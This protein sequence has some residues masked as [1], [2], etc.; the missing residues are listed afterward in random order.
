MGDDDYRKTLQEMVDGTSD[1]SYQDSENRSSNR[2]S[3]WSGDNDDDDDVGGEEDVEDEETSILEGFSIGDNVSD[4][5]YSGRPNFD[6]QGLHDKLERQNTLIEKQI[7]SQKQQLKL[8]V[9]LMLFNTVT[10]PAVYYTATSRVW[11]A[12]GMFAFGI[13]ATVGVFLRLR[14]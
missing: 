10:L 4:P 13:I 5:D 8:T 6:I 14:D 3:N 11:L 1:D 7:K 9:G 12:V 2:S